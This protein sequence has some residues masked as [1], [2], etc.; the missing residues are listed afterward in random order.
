[1]SR[2]RYLTSLELQQINSEVT[3]GES[4]IRDA[5]LLKSAAA[6]PTLV[7]FGEEQFPTLV[8]K[9]AALLHSMAYHHLFTDGNKRT[10]VKVVERFLAL[11][12]H[13]I[14]WDYASEY[15][16]LLEVAKGNKDVYEVAEWLK[17]LVKPLPAEHTAD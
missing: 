16:F 15:P 12:N 17:P 3:G 14:A 10:A 7:I 5:H 8:D 4:R 9:A 2:I 6:R 11:N 1:V 13:S